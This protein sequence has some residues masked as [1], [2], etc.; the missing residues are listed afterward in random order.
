[1]SSSGDVLISLFFAVHPQ[2]LEQVQQSMIVLSRRVQEHRQPRRSGTKPST[3]KVSGLSVL[4]AKRGGPSGAER[5]TSGGS[6]MTAAAE[7]LFLCEYAADI[8]YTLAATLAAA[9]PTQYPLGVR[10]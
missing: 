3:T 2:A 10:W 7:L 5:S 9:N 1:M 8:V 4:P 6:K